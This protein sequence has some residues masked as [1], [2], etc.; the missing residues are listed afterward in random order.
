MNLQR[1][2]FD[3]LQEDPTNMKIKIYVKG[4]KGTVKEKWKGV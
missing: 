2:D 3:S 1:L 4:I